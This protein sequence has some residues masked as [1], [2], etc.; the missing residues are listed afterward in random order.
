MIKLIIN[1]KGKVS[2]KN[3]LLILS[4]SQGK[5]TMCEIIELYFRSKN[6][7]I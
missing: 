7:K 5:T 1:S 3:I 2:I 6:V 4:P